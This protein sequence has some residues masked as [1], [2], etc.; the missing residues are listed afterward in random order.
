MA[1]P[2]VARHG[3][4]CLVRGGRSEVLEGCAAG[5][6]VGIEFPSVAAAR[7]FYES[8]ECQAIVGM[9]RATSRVVLVEGAAP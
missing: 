8:L 1:S 7:A 3:G 4:I 6:V 5:R 9:R 2:I